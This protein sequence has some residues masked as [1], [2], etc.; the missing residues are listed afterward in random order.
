MQSAQ[1]AAVLVISPDGR[2]ITDIASPAE[3]Q[4]RQSLSQHGLFQCETAESYLP[5]HLGRGVGGHA[6]LLLFLMPPRV[7]KT[8]SGAPVFL[9]LVSL[10]QA[11]SL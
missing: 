10:A 5:E 3:R 8:L 7:F 9:P 6:C 1:V 2:A 4:S 11:L